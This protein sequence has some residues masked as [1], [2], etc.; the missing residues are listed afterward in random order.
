KTD[1]KMI[2]CHLGNGS[3]LCA[4][5]N[6]KCMDTSMG[7]SPLAGVPMGTRRGDIA[8][9]VVQSISHKYGMPV[10]DCLTTLHTK[11]GGL[12]LADEAADFRDLEDGEKHGD[13][14]CILALQ[15]FFYEVAKYI[16]AYTAALNGVDVITFT[17]GV[18]ENGPETRQTICDYLGYLGVKIDPEKN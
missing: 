5:E 6:G 12:A 2:N 1:F 4:I 3:S 11:S 7:L 17:A 9:C 16:G 8:A 10:D 15:K 18:G 14:K 13:E